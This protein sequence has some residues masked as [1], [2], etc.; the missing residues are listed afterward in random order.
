MTKCAIYFTDTPINVETAKYTEISIQG[1]QHPAYE[2][3]IIRSSSSHCLN[4]HSATPG[5]DYNI[6]YLH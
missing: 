6:P 4:K 3:V 1:E 2:D 5:S